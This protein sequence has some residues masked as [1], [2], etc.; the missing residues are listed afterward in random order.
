MLYEECPNIRPPRLTFGDGP[1]HPCHDHNQGCRRTTILSSRGG[2]GGRCLPWLFTL[3]SPSNTRGMSDV[4]IPTRK[5][6][7][8]S[9][10]VARPDNVVTTRISLSPTT[11]RANQPSTL[12][13]A[14]PM[15][16]TC[17]LT[18]QAPTTLI[19]IDM[20]SRP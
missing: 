20:E 7:I 15:S 16:N 10:P 14:S 12:I 2:G 18:L 1:S 13:S 4:F 11:S 19:S 5:R 6:R 3:V 17:P 8:E 9:S